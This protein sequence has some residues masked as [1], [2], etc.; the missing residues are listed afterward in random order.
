MKSLLRS[1]L[2]ALALTTGV[3]L[4]VQAKTFEEPFTARERKDYRTAFAGYTKLAAKGD[5]EAQYNLGHMYANGH[6]VPRSEQKA[7]E[8][9]RKA[10]NQGDADAQYSLARMYADGR[11][12]RAGDVR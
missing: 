5:A 1:L 8:W 6:G 10:A 2:L 4:S 11:G 7:V 3:W 12:L 9:Y